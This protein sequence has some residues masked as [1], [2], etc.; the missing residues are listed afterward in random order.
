MIENQPFGNG[1]YVSTR[2]S[3]ANTN[4]EPYTI[5]NTEVPGGG[6]WASNRY[7]LTKGIFWTTTGI[8]TDYPG[9]GSKYDFQYQF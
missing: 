3:F 2:I 6:Q 4:L 7:S 1:Y 5:F 8:E 9:K